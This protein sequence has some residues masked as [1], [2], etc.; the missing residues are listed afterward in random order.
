MLISY[1]HVANLGWICTAS[2]FHC[3]E[4]E[5]PADFILDVVLTNQKN[6]NGN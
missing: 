1:I 6:E 2:G 3:E 5:N 4:H